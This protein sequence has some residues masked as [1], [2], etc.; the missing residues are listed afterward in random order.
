MYLQSNLDLVVERLDENGQRIWARSYGL[1]GD[2]RTGSVVAVDDGF[3]MT[4]RMATVGTTAG[5]V[6]LIARLSA[7]GEMSGPSNS[8]MA[9]RPRWHMR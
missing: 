5:V 1:G 6:G 3:I 7:T 2:D 9:T 4:G 8:A